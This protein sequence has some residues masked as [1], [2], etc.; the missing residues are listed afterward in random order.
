LKYLR[1]IRERGRS[2][3]GKNIRVVVLLINNLWMCLNV[4]LWKCLDDLDVF[5]C[6][7]MTSRCCFDD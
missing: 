2:R 1:L 5:G 6:N 4:L 7:L 3:N